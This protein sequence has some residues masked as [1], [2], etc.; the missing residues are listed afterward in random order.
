[1]AT[2]TMVSV[3]KAACKPGTNT[4]KLAIAPDVKMPKYVV[5]LRKISQPCGYLYRCFV[6]NKLNH[7]PITKLKKNAD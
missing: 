3:L 5:L 4:T 1:M 7:C 6:R 2:A